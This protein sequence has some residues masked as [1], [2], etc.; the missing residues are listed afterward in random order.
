LKKSLETVPFKKDLLTYISIALFI[1]ALCGELMLIFWLPVQ[2]KSQTIWT[3]EVSLQEM[4]KFLDELRD[5]I[6]GINAKTRRQDKEAAMLCDA[7]D[8]LARYIRINA[9][10]L[11]IDQIGDIQ[12]VLLD[13]RESCDYFR[14]GK[15]YSEEVQIDTT[16]CL[17]K[18]FAGLTPV[19]EKENEKDSK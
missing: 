12:S 18:M 9:K 17:K 19:V 8:N 7:V 14:S 13:C 4:I 10:S 5:D 2:L 3:K 15:Q 1:L 16:P 11:S 6:R